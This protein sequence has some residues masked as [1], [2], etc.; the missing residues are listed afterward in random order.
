MKCGYDR[1][2]EQNKIVTVGKLK[3]KY[4]KME[5]LNI[6]TNFTFRQIRND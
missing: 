4:L 5:L 2:E 3:R 1:K 6:P